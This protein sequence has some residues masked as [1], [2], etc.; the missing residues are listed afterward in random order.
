MNPLNNLFELNYSKINSYSYCPFLY[1]FVYIDGKYIPFNPYSSF[2]MSI[3]MTL[4]RYAKEKGDFEDLLIYYEESWKHEG[5]NSPSEMMEFY[6]KGKKILE[7]FWLEEQKRNSEII[8]SETDFEF[9]L[10]DFKIK[11]TIDRV[12]RL[13]NNKIELIEYKT[14]LEERDIERLK[15]DRQLAIYALGLKYHYS[16]IPDYISFYLLSLNKKITAEY[17]IDSE[18]N[19]IEYLHKIGEKIRKKD[20]SFKGNCNNCIIKNLCKERD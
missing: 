20:F 4:A 3:H 8:F 12:D 13:S 11:G 16:I 14:G 6:Q 9:N 5:Y 15:N 19:I 7:N 18:N 10:K 1:K 17:N 2:G